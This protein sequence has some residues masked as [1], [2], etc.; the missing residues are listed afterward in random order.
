MVASPSICLPCTMTNG[1]YKTIVSLGD[2]NKRNKPSADSTAIASGATK[3]ETRDLIVSNKFDLNNDG[4]VN[5]TDVIILVNHILGK[6]TYDGNADLN[7][8]EVVSVADVV[9]L[10]DIILNKT[11]TKVEGNLSEITF[12]GGGSGPARSRQLDDNDNE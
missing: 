4:Y 2:N 5:M 8:D 7:N 1:E 12:D 9:K 11:V 3:K 6:S 10:V